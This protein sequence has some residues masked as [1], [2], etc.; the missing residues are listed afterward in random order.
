MYEYLYGVLM[1]LWGV[2][3]I[4]L[5]SELL[6]TDEPA[7]CWYHSDSWR[8]QCDPLFHCDIPE[9]TNWVSTRQLSTDVDN[10]ILSPPPFPFSYSSDTIQVP[11]VLTVILDTS[12]L[13][14]LTIQSI[15]EELVRVGESLGVEFAVSGVQRFGK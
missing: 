7:D 4:M 13:S 2:C 11:I 8:R 14:N 15:S 6:S 3:I 1:K 12:P 9:C 5:M 10:P